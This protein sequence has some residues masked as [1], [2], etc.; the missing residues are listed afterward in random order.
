MW[1]DMMMDYITTEVNKKES[2]ITHSAL[3][4]VMAQKQNTSEE[5]SIA[6][7]SYFFNLINIS[8]IHVHY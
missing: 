6:L 3:T 4:G 8:I 1:T 2:S 7:K 5:K